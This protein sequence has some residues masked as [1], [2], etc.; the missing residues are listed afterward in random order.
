MRDLENTRACRLLSHALGPFDPVTAR[1][2]PRLMRAATFYI[3]V[4]SFAHT[5]PDRDDIQLAWAR[6]ANQAA[7]TYYTVANPTRHHI[8]DMYARVC[9]RQGLTFDAA[10]TR[11]RELTAYTT[12]GPAEDIPHA[13]RE[14]AVAL[15]ADGQCA[16]AHSQIQEAFTYWKHTDVPA[17]PTG[18]QLLSTYAGILAGCGDTDAAH[19]LLRDH[20]YLVAVP[21]TDQRATAAFITAVQIAVA[22][23]EHPPVCTLLPQR[24]P[25]PEADRWQGWQ[26]VLLPSRS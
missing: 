16:E 7:R 17:Q 14:L 10:I 19:T 13:W 6:Y 18:G 15:H 2:D 20:T 12:Y 5:H 25:P 21:G 22:E 11:R 3:D 23:R 9:T 24:E 8:A 4:L 1:H 26:A